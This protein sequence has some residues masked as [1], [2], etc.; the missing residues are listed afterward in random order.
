[1][2]R[3]FINISLE[4]VLS[5]VGALA[6][7]ASFLALSS[8]DSAGQTPCNSHPPIQSTP[9]SQASLQSTSMPSPTTGTPL[10]RACSMERLS[11]LLSEQTAVLAADGGPAVPSQQPMSSVL[12]EHDFSSSNSGNSARKIAGVAACA[13]SRGVL[14]STKCTAPVAGAKVQMPKQTV[15]RGIAKANSNG[16]GKRVLQSPAAAA[17]M[18]KNQSAL[19]KQEAALR[20]KVGLRHN[21]QMQ[22]KK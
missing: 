3:G 12:L 22:Q 17:A 8:Q 6:E 18:A 7:T 9:S 15:R 19:E 4:P 13:R 20:A 14:G 2:K 1:M 11:S 10:E 16:S 5:Q 21:S